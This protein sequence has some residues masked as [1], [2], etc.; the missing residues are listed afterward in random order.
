MNKNIDYC[1]ENRECVVWYLGHSGW[2]MKTKNHFLI[3]DY[4][5]INT[6]V[7]DKEIHNSFINS[8]D[9]KNENVYVFVSHD[10]DDHYDKVIF[11]W[12]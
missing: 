6:V 9:L 3:F 11:S 4:T 12:E 7:K 1:L 2:A 10:H 5:E 8:T